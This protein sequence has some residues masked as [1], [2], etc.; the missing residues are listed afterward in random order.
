MRSVG[1]GNSNAAKVSEAGWTGHGDPERASAGDRQIRLREVMGPRGVQWVPRPPTGRSIVYWCDLTAKTRR[2]L[3]L[4]YGG[5]PEPVTAFGSRRPRRPKT[6]HERRLVAVGD[7][8]HSRDH[9]AA[10]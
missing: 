7:V 3:L 1:A 4:S 10:K 5:C 9:P 2:R 8:E 6:D